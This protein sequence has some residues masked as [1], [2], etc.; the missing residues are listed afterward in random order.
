V[1]TAELRKLYLDYFVE[2]GHLLVPSSALVP[3][4]DASVLLTTAG[5]QQFMPYFLGLAEPP[6][7]RLTSVQKCFRTSDIDKLDYLG[8]DPDLIWISY[9]EGDDE[10]PADDDAV[11][12]WEAMGV[13]R[14]RMV[15]LPRSANFWGPVGPTGPCGP[16]SELYFDRG[17]D[18]GCSDPECRPGCDCDRYVEYWNLVFTGY[19]MGEDRQLTALPAQNIDTGMGLERVAALK[20]GVDSVF[21]TDQFKPLVELGEEI[22]SKRYG[23]ERTVDVALRV[24]ADH[25]RAMSFLVADG[26]LPSNEG[27]GYV[28]RRIV[29]RAARFSRSAGMEPPFLERFAART[30]DLMGGTY[31]EL[32]DRRDVILRTVGSEEER[33]NR[34][35]DQGLV[36]VEEAIARA[37]DEGSRVFPGAVAFQLHDTYGFP[38]EVTREI[39]EERGLAL[40]LAGF[41]SS[42][43]SQRKRARRAQKGGDALQ[44]AIVRFAR[45]TEHATEFRGYEREDLYTVVENLEALE[46]GRLLL[47]LRESPFYAEMGG[48]TADTGLVEADCGKVRVE[49]VQQQGE[50]QVIVARP[51]EGELEAG[52][53]VKAS[54]SASYRHDVAA[55]HTA[56]HLLHYALRSRLGKDVHQAGSS[57]RADKFRFDFAY[58]EPIGREHLKEIEELVNRRIVENHPVRTFTTSLEHARDLGATALFGEKY[59]D[60]VRVVEIDDF[61]RELCGGTH[62]AW[63]SEVGA[64]K[65]LSEGSVGAN[66][67]RIEA[68][69]GRAAVSYYRD[70]DLLVSSAASV[71]GVTEDQLLPGLARL[72]SKVATLESELGDLVSLAAKDVVTSLAGEAV[73][74]SGVSVVASAVEA[75]DMDHLLTLVDQVRERTQPS[76]VALGAELTGKATLVVST[77]PQVSKVNAGQVVKTA[78]LV[79]GGGGGGTAHLGRGG[80]GDPTKLKDAVAS[81]RDAILAALSD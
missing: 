26:V 53:R 72:Q 58:H 46:D 29:R 19:N 37:E 64:F 24:L 78:S 41:D 80:G 30:I 56:T 52:V 62:V 70:R 63:T 7:R 31:P 21:L 33:F 2:R 17:R 5:M 73:V 39:V 15:G 14:E 61:S 35:L 59:G 23:D 69:S 3:Y 20:Q 68:V 36:L 45:E 27:R 49:D 81:A 10:I 77:S 57:V 25:S 40:D 54:L 18:Y 51:L 48:Q 67:R 28:L 74:R 65:I 6:S 32:I 47:A 43:E 8:L 13:P 9:F 22:A 50:V 4:R 42:M 71:L 60:F 79:F 11:A 44:E 55:N 34:T 12:L 16:C 66:V 75:R 76:V 38:V 1:K